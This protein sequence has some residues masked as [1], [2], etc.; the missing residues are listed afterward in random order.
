MK[1]IYLTL[2]LFIA[3][4]ITSS[5]TAQTNVTSSG[6]SIQGIARD[7][8]NAAIANIDQ[9]ALVFTVYYFGTGNSEQVIWYC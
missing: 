9:L 4:L 6:M 1:Q 5:V 8:N 3:F 7:E 2:S